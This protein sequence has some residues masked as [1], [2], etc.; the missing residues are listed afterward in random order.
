MELHGR[1]RIS[2]LE[3]FVGTAWQP[4]ERVHRCGV[5]VRGAGNNACCLCAFAMLH[6]V[7]TDESQP[8]F[9][10]RLSSLQ[11]YT[12]HLLDSHLRHSSDL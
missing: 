2:G 8:S 11:D 1:H 7:M 9:F 6:A 3:P 4:M 5:R 10:S 12:S